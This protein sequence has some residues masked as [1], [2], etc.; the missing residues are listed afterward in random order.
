MAAATRAPLPSVSVLLPYATQSV[1]AA[2]RRLGLDLHRR[3]LAD[4]TI[5][6]LLSDD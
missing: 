6:G 3:G 5:A 1:R 4:D 2:R